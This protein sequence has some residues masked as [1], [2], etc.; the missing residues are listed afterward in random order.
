MPEKRSALFNDTRLHLFTGGSPATPDELAARYV[1]LSAGQ[2][3]DG[4]QA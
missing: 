1:R 2:S 4:S 3:P